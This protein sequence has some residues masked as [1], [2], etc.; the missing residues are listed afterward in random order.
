[1]KTQEVTQGYALSSTGLF[2]RTNAGDRYAPAMPK[3]GSD[4][5]SPN[6]VDPE[7]A[8]RWLSAQPW[9][10]CRRCKEMP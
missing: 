4:I 6:W 9:D 2:H 10:L 5:G 3:C 1:M 8:E 7:F